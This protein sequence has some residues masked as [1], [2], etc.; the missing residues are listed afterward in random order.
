MTG[1]SNIILITVDSL[2]YDTI[3]SDEAVSA[4]TIEQLIEEGLT[5]KRAYANG[6]STGMS[7]PS[8]FSGMYP[9]DYY[10]SYYSPDRPHLIE[11]F[12]NTNYGTAAFH[13]NPHLSASFGYDRGFDIFSEGSDSPST[14]SKLRKKAGNNIPKDSIL[15]DVLRKAWKNL[16]KATGTGV[17][18]PYVDGT[19]LNEYVFDWLESASA[20]VFGWVHY[21]DV[22]HPY[23]P[24]K[25]TVSH[26][27]GEKEAI[28]LRQKFIHSP[29]DLVNSEIEILRQLYR[30]EVEYFDRCLNSLL[31]KVQSELGFDN[32]VLILVSDHGE[33]FGENDNY[34]HGGDALGDEVTRVPL[35]IRGPNIEP[36]KVESPVSCVDIYPTITDIRGES[37][38]SKCRGKS[39]LAVDENERQEK[40]EKQYV[41]AHANA[42][43]DGQAMICDG[44]RKLIHDRGENTD[45]LYDLCD[46]QEKERINYRADHVKDLVDEIETHISS[47]KSSDDSAIQPDIDDEMKNKLRDLGY[48][49]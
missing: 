21:M 36:S 19:E 18:T 27:I 4:P 15:Y 3:F 41:F 29:D 43:S 45:T 44:R 8:I 11:E 25:N 38:P 47:I 26:D 20:P 6:T 10:G 40:D 42:P 37:A 39:L 35:I 16:E 2:R 1:N 31:S 30:G 9:W 34:G 32:T 17:G 13:S 49:D 14:V 22:H 33:A 23:L 24:H 28:R 7:F 46:G 12:K 48:I 5:F